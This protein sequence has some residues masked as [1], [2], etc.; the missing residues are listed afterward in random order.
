MYTM[1]RKRT[2]SWQKTYQTQCT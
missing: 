2:H 1:A